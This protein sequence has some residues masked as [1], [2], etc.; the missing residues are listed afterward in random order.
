MR[1]ASPFFTSPGTS[2]GIVP[3]SKACT[4]TVLSSPSISSTI[5]TPKSGTACGNPPDILEAAPDRHEAVLA[6]GQ[7]ASL[8]AVGAQG[9]HA[10]DV[11]SVVCGEERLGDRLYVQR[12]AHR[13][14]IGAA[15][16]D[17][18]G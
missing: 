15:V 2:A 14:S 4:V 13:S 10:L 17:S 12:V 18:A 11:V 1:S 5:S 7:V 6:I 3:P 9:Q 16:V 8:G